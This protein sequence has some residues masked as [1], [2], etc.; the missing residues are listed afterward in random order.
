MRN[1]KNYSLYV[2][3]LKCGSANLVWDY[4][5]ESDGKRIQVGFKFDVPASFF[6]A[7][8]GL[9][10][11]TAPNAGLLNKRVME[12]GD[13]VEAA[14][15]DCIEE[16]ELREML[17]GKPRRYTNRKKR[18]APVDKLALV[19]TGPGLFTP[20]TAPDY[21]KMPPNDIFFD[22]RQQEL[23]AEAADLAEAEAALLVA[24][25]PGL[26]TD[27]EA[28]WIVINPETLRI[29]GARDENHALY[30]LDEMTE[31]GVIG[32]VYQ[33]RYTTKISVER[34]KH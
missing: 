16:S 1:G 30:I 33:R 2:S 17:G 34:I 4:R 18:Y 15:T 5:R 20:P 23:D 13:T 31:R 9:F 8:I 6:N 19:A 26:I 21:T 25:R 14:Q 24:T 27:D 10:V 32:V 3:A 29:T 28:A 11:D 7:K 22:N 12:V